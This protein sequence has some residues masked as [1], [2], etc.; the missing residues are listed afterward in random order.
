M[1]GELQV[2]SALVPTRKLY[3]LRF[4]QQIEAGS[5]AI[6]DVSYDVPNQ[7]SQFSSWSKAHKLPSGCLI[8]KM[9]NGYSKVCLISNVCIYI[10][11]FY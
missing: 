2:L 1:Y 11:V 9:P 8:Q 6:V 10:V 3:F 5:W 7:E 4:V